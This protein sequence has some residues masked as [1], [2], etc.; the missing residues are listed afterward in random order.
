MKGLPPR[1]RPRINSCNYD[2]DRTTSAPRPQGPREI[3]FWRRNH[4]VADRTERRWEFRKSRATKSSV[5]QGRLKCIQ[6]KKMQ[7]KLAHKL[8]LFPMGSTS[9]AARPQLSSLR[10][11]HCGS[12]AG[13]YRLYHFRER[14]VLPLTIIATASRV[15]PSPARA[16][17]PWGTS[18][19]A[20][21][22]DPCSSVK[23]RSLAAGMRY[24]AVDTV[25]L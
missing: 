18:V 11:P 14:K 7:K 4:T 16:R 10:H 21:A 19:S 9:E 3:L 24:H 20:P 6:K 15:L 17:E 1:G 25:I 2:A 8:V 23:I 12:L 5:L 13:S 22:G